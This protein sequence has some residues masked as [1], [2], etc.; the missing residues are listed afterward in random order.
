MVEGRAQELIGL[1]DELDAAL[2]R[3]A[4]TIKTSLQKWPMCCAVSQANSAQGR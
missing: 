1:R 4:T 2:D 3:I